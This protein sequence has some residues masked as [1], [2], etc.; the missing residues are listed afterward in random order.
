MDLEV[1]SREDLVYLIAFLFESFLIQL[2]GIGTIAVLGCY[3]P[4][5]LGSA[6][7]SCLLQ[8]R[9]TVK[10]EERQSGILSYVRKCL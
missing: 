10:I 1:N 7:G 6:S 3:D 9:S 5:P 2:F 8:H 4:R